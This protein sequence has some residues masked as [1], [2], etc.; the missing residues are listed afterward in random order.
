MYL[1][2]PPG[3]CAPPL[4]IVCLSLCQ[5]SFGFVPAI[6]CLFRCTHLFTRQP[7]HLL[8]ISYKLPAKKTALKLQCLNVDNQLQSG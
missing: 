3:A 2:R 7:L 1:P 6:G 5:D 4:C 8:L